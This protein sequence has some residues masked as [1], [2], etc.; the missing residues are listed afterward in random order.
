M[1]RGG[2]RGGARQCCVSLRSFGV[3]DIGI[4]PLEGG[5][6]FIFKPVFFL[7]VWGSKHRY[8][9]RL[10]VN[11]EV[12][13]VCESCRGKVGIMDLLFFFLKPSSS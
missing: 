4:F 2:G 1:W 7:P 10:T 8:K 12:P 13:I 5:T 6:G 3:A 9:N 11:D